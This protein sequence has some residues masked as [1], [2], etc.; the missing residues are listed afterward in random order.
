MD[1]ST[2]SRTISFCHAKFENRAV[3]YVVAESIRKS[4]L[5]LMPKNI[6]I[7]LCVSVLVSVSR[8]ATAQDK[9]APPASRARGLE[10]PTWHIATYE[11]SWRRHKADSYLKFES[12]VI[13]GSPGCGRLTGIYS[14]SNEQLTISI[15]WSDRRE[16]P[17]DDDEREVARK[18]REA[19]THVQRIQAPPPSWHSDSLSLADAEG[20]IQ[21]TLT[22]MQ[23]GADLSELEDTFWHLEELY[24]SQAD[25][26]G[27][28]VN[29]R[30]DAID[31]ST[32]SHI[33][34][35]SFRYQWGRLEF[36]PAYL[37]WT[38]S[39]DSKV[40]QDQQ[41]AT[42]FD[43]T[44]QKTQSY[45]LSHGILTF[46]DK[47]RRPIM[48]LSDFPK[49]GIENRRWRIA[50]YRGYG[51]QPL[52][53]PF[54]PTDGFWLDLFQRSPEFALKVAQSGP[55]DQ[56]GL[57]NAKRAEM[58]LLNSR[59]IGSP[60]CGGWWGTYKLSGDRLKVEAILSLFGT[61]EPEGFAQDYLV[62]NAFKGDLRVE[63]KGDRILLRD[64]S[65]HAHI[66]LVSY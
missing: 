4:E 1:K 34:L 63:K 66:L 30:G 14:K 48:V 60:G 44:L 2:N 26:S 46:F 47:N 24:S 52:P 43:K 13:E 64:N 36:N 31:L 9:P 6:L 16:T 59:V 21:I 51:T 12:G 33:I 29:I 22:P 10:G 19:L 53:L 15:G 61:C 37:R 27:V 49:E 8:P 54:A 3:Q 39:K 42:S 62:E 20:S 28:I 25:L 11:N 58:T 32:F 56:D 5:R 38:E 55:V 23:A 50:K 40:S 18:I 45:E 65:G 35:F 41:I 57:V 17:C 7:C